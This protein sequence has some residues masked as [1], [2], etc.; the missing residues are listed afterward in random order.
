MTTLPASA[1]TGQ[2]L[3]WLRQG[4][5]LQ[6]HKRA[7]HIELI[8]LV[9][10]PLHLMLQELPHY[11]NH[12]ILVLRLQTYALHSGVLGLLHPQFAMVMVMDTSKE[13]RMVLLN[14]S[15]M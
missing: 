10:A 7:V 1:I 6:L 3:T 4:K 5:M 11:T 2:R 13:T 15:C 8:F 14:R 12:F 9:R